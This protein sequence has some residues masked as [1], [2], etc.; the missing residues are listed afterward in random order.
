MKKCCK[1]SHLGADR[2]AV[3][4]RSNKD[5]LIMVHQGFQREASLKA[6]TKSSQAAEDRR[7]NTDLWSTLVYTLL[8]YSSFSR[9]V[10]LLHVL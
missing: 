3:Q 4:H 8:N 9:P 7:F 10:F 6:G 1:C 2:T 5:M